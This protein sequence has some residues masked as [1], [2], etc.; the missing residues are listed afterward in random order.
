MQRNSGVVGQPSA[1]GAG[2]GAGAGGTGSSIGTATVAMQ[3]QH[4]AQLVVLGTIW[5]SAYLF[6]TSLVDE[7]SP[8][9]MIL[10]RLL[11]GA[12]VL[13][14][15]LI[16]RG[17]RLPER[18]VV[19]LHLAAMAVLG[20]LLPF[21]L[22]AWSQQHATSSIAAVLNAT[23]PFFTLLTAALVFRMER[24]RANH[25]LGVLLGTIGTLA[26]TGGS[27]LDLGSTTGQG[28]LALLVS[29][30]CYGVAFA[31]ARRFV[32]GEPVAL[33]TAQL[34]VGAV[35]CAPLAWQDW[36]VEWGSLGVL[37]LLAWLTLGAIGTGFAY[38]IYYA[39]IADLGA[40]AASFVTYLIP[41]VGVLLGWLVLSESL[42]W[43]GLLGM[44]LIA[45]GVSVS[46]GLHRRV[47][48]ALQRRGAE[49]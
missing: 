46:Y 5:G 25:L 17:G 29:S 30:A 12:G 18:G 28:E 24:I 41:V 48:P 14:L 2:A 49:V 38:V 31:Y 39:L 33:V 43:L 26:L 6:I 7:V 13:G 32:R 1:G 19:W 27:L 11:L 36:R 23:I 15:V 21:W 22:I 3:P 10:V 34:L 9:A 37:E 44:L 47:L 16:A 40:T 20:N 45:L 8:W 4:V 35:L 42:G